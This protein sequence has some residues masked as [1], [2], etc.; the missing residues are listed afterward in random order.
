MTPSPSKAGAA[1][2]RMRVWGCTQGVALGQLLSPGAG[3][4]PSSAPSPLPPYRPLRVQ[5]EATL[6]MG[7]AGL[8]GGGAATEGSER[9]PATP[10]WVLHA[11]AA[12]LPWGRDQGG[13][14]ATETHM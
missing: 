10:G 12:T 7:A 11:S 13:R 5:W 2:S 4:Y 14:S 3:G 8:V 9:L 6:P 1:E